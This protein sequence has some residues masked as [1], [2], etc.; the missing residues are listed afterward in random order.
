MTTD[1]I[2]PD[3]PDDGD[4]EPDE[5]SAGNG[6]PFGFWLKLVDRRISEELESLFAADGITRRDWRLLN[7]LAGTARDERLAERLRAKPHA[8]HRLAERGWVEGFPPEL[9]DAGRDARDRLEGQVGALRERIAGAVSPE[10]FATTLRS[11][12][13]IA[14]E[15]GWDESQPLPRG[16]RGGRRFGFGAR[17]GFGHRFGGEAPHFAPHEFGPHRGFS[18]F[19][20]F[21]PR[22]GFGARSGFGGRPAP[23]DVHVHVHVH[24]D[25]HGER[26]DDRHESRKGKGHGHRHHDRPRT[27][28]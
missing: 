25:R 14:R 22:P 6:R 20:G 2:N 13:A 11:L 10:D 27:D 17:H 5:A 28:A 12:G 8:L 18:P 21:G 7:L 19:E 1:Q 9:T 3:Q 23:Q 24:D 16:R 4:D 26:H 15:L